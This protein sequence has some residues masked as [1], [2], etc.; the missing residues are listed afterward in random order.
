[1]GDGQIGDELSSQVFHFQWTQG[2]IPVQE[3]LMD[4]RNGPMA[5]EQRP[6]DKNQDIPGHIAPGWDQTAQIFS[7]KGALAFWT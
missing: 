4:L 5:L 1:M 2:D 3:C 6:P 7:L